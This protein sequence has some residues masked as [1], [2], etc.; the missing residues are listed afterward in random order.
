MQ[1]DRQFL[2]SGQAD[3]RPC[4][5]DWV[6]SLREQCVACGIPFR[7]HQTGA[8]FIKDG[9]M[10]YVKRCYQLSQAHKANIDYKTKKG[11]SLSI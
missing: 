5:Y 1:E 3:A 6:L 9:K 7:F 11:V 2:S 10:Y 8:R 4:N